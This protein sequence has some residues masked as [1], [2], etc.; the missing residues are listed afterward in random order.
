MEMELVGFICGIM[1]FSKS[2][3]AFNVRLNATVFV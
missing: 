2:D 1:L 3:D